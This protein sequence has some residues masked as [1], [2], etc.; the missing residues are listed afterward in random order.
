MPAKVLTIQANQLRKVSARL[1]S[2]AEKYSLLTAALM[3]ISGTI[4]ACATFLDVL[5]ATR[6]ST[7][8]A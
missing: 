5:V 1:E 8:P 4:H 7:K 2:V 3:A 6:L